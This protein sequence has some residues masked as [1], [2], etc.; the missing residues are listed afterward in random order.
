MKIFPNVCDHKRRSFLKLSGL[1]GLGAAAATLLPVEKAESLLFHKNTY[2]VSKTR[3]AMG[4]FV[5]MTVMHTSR[6]E[7]ENAMGLAFAE[8]DR[9][10]TLL[11][12]YGNQ[13]PIC[14]LNTEHCLAQPIPEIREVLGRALYFH[15][16]TNGAF[17]ITVAPLVDLF[18]KR[19]AAGKQPTEAETDAILDLIGSER[20]RFDNGSILLPEKGM[21]ITL[22]GVAPGF[23][24]DR[25]AQ[26][27]AENG[28]AN[29]LVNAGG[30]IRVGGSVAKGKAWTVAIQDPA[31]K[32]EYPDVISL[33]EG[34]VATSGNYEIYYDREKVFHHIVNSKTGHSPHLATS[35]TVMAPTAMDADILST[36]VFVMEPEVGMRYINSR[37]GYECFVIDRQGQTMHSNGWPA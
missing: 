19:F 5:D 1:L 10:C 13:S 18:Q 7:A 26:V 9:L 15:R 24:A 8:V 3:I 17:D 12:R 34:A 16:D 36:A 14:E 20:L 6:D 31:K 29:H 28:I 25:A 11:T 21:G 4:T 22:D 30:E 32:K 23:I 2:K 37:P 35:V 27:L 33:R